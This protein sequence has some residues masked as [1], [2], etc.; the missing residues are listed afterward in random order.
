MKHNSETENAIK[1]LSQYIDRPDKFKA[2]LK[3]FLVT[4]ISDPLQD[5][6]LKEF[7]HEYLRRMYLSTQNTDFQE[8]LRQSVK[9]LFIDWNIY[10]EHTETVDYYASLLRLIAELPVS[11][12]YSDLIEAA[13]PGNYR[14]IPAASE[15]KDVQTLLF[16]VIVGLPLPTDREV[17]HRA[18]FLAKK[19]VYDF[20]YTPLCFRLLWQLDIRNAIE[21]I[22]PLMECAQYRKFDL[23]GTLTRF[24][25][26]CGALG[27][28]KLV[29]P[30]LHSLQTNQLRWDFLKGLLSLG[31]E[32]H[33]PRSSFP[34]FMSY[35]RMK[36]WPF[37]PQYLG[38]LKVTIK[39]KDQNVID[40][41]DKV[42]G[43]KYVDE[44]ESDGLFKKFIDNIF[45]PVSPPLKTA[46][47]LP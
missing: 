17:R 3:G 22:T 18:M 2:W 33:I 9:E 23:S 14:D 32:L 4:K 1:E 44:G 42:N 10:A 39:K 21:F 38:P 36:N 27:F 34:G 28:I 35:L 41:I 12:V 6:S 40:Q 29:I 24:L 45:P 13:N 20:R 26:G 43:E 37:E 8:L 11:E 30:M 47:S 15:K 19:Y 5:Y 16:R 31:V 7:P 46:M 25:E